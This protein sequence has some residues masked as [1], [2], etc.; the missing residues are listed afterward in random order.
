ML[1]CLHHAALSLPGLCPEC[2]A[3]YDYDPDSWVEYGHHE[4]GEARYR[5]LLEEIAEYAARPQVP[6]DPTLPF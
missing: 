4:A 5:A 3:E 6:D 1:T 2:Q